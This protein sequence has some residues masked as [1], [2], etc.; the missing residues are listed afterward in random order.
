MKLKPQFYGTKVIRG[1]FTFDSEINNA[2][3]YP[4]FYKNGF[5]DLFESEEIETPKEQIVD[6]KKFQSKLYKGI[7]NDDK[8]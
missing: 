8:K 5:S 2:A 7:K 4:F 6:V 3:E 1:N